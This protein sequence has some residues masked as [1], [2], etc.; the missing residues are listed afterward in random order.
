M[1]SIASYSSVTR[2]FLRAQPTQTRIQKI[3]E[4]VENCWIVTTVVGFRYLGYLAKYLKESCDRSK[5]IH[6]YI[7][8]IKEIKNDPRYK[9]VAIYYHNNTF[10]YG[11]IPRRWCGCR[12]KPPIK[13]LTN[14]AGLNP[15]EMLDHLKKC[16]FEY[17]P[18]SQDVTFFMLKYSWQIT[19]INHL[20][21]AQRYK[22]DLVEYL[23]KLCYRITDPNGRKME[24][25][26]PNNQTMISMAERIRELSEMRVS[27]DSNG[28][29]LL[30][31]LE[32]KKKIALSDSSDVIEVSLLRGKT[33]MIWQMRRPESKSC[34]QFEVEPRE[35]EEPQTKSLALIGDTNPLFR[36]F[37]GRKAR[38]TKLLFFQKINNHEVTVLQDKPLWPLLCQVK[39]SNSSLEIS[40]QSPCSDNLS[41]NS[42]NGRLNI[43]DFY[44]RVIERR[45]SGTA[46]P[47]LTIALDKQTRFSKI[48]SFTSISSQYWGVTLVDSGTSELSS[49]WT[50]GGHAK[51]IVE[52]IKEGLYFRTAYHFVYD[53]E[54]APTGILINDETEST[55]HYPNRTRVYLRDRLFVQNMI[56]DIIKQ[57]TDGTSHYTVWGGNCELKVDD[58]KAVGANC[59]TWARRQLA[60]ANINLHEP[61]DSNASTAHAFRNIVATPVLYTQASSLQGNEYI[62]FFFCKKKRGWLKTSLQPS[63]LNIKPILHKH[64]KDINWTVHPNV[65]WD[66][67]ENGVA[68]NI[69]VPTISLPCTSLKIPPIRIFINGGHL[70]LDLSQDII[71]DINSGR[72]F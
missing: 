41:F 11:L 58:E 67:G 23:D 8:F 9:R 31:K 18:E 43:N 50:W 28:L 25:Q 71:Q 44:L 70:D 2:P 21:I 55:R 22:I 48:D 39:L 57:R 60:K 59:I 20:Q 46:A 13:Q 4:V 49:P 30:S 32:L 7:K 37:Q 64:V 68:K 65:D 56:D 15:T 51:I 5:P 72:D 66:V 45:P 14:I 1:A 61:E 52:G 6:K 10:F 38:L 26:I 33:S 53:P 29:P 36:E 42:E 12:Q 35:L 47:F 19:R 24:Y 54:R 40:Y 16:E 27:I 69:H 34:L 63:T 17:N 62:F 3:K